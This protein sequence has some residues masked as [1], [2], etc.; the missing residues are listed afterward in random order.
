MILRAAIY[1]RRSHP[2]ADAEDESKSVNRQVENAR[3]FA[4][5]KGWTV[6]DEHIYIDDGISGASSPA[7]LRAKGM[8]EA[9]SQDLGV[10]RSEVSARLKFAKKFPTEAEVSTVIESSK[11]WSAIRQQA[12]TDTPRPSSRQRT[13]LHRAF[14]LVEHI[15]PETLNAGDFML[16]EKFIETLQR[17][18]GNIARQCAA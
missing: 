11:S 18:A 12:L 6:L 10:H 5:A 7:R 13:P 14:T 15:E 3:V 2:Q 16:I 17:L 8:L 4:T 1:A 9:L